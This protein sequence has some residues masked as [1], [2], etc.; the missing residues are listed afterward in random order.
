MCLEASCWKVAI[1]M[2]LSGIGHPFVDQN[3][4]RA[5]L[6]H[7]HSQRVTGAGCPLVVLPDFLKSRFA[8]ELPGELAPQ[9]LDDRSIGLH[10]RVAR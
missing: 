9:G 1:I 10:R 7:K 4:T 5:V 8:P 3:Q 6:V 2:Q